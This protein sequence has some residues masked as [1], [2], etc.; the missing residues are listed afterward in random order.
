MAENNVLGDQVNNYKNNLNRIN[1]GIASVQ[2]KMR[3]NIAKKIADRLS[4]GSVKVKVDKET[5]SITLLMDDSF[6]FK[7]NDYRLSQV[8]K[9]TL[10]EVIP[11]YIDELFK[12]E[13]VREAISSVNIIGHASPR[14]KRQFVEPNSI[15]KPSAYTYNLELSS[16]RAKEIV[17]YIFGGDFGD[18]NHKSIFRKKYPLLER[19]LVNLSVFFHL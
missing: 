4:K 5:G 3:S 19:A 15:E 10:K 8:A 13:L 11:P 6:L 7:R 9:R 16:N 2:R 18:F 12:D 1:R 17:K 14:F